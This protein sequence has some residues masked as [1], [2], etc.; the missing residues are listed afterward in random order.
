MIKGAQLAMVETAKMHPAELESATTFNA[1]FGLFLAIALI[2]LALASVPN[3]VGVR[4]DEQAAAAAR[5]IVE[6]THDQGY[7]VSRSH[8]AK[9]TA[10]SN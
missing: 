7:G 10:I 4:T 6:G 1:I 9:C 3:I 2:C 8:M 5:P